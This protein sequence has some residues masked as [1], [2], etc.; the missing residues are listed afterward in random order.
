[1]M[2]IEYAMFYGLLGGIVRIAIGYTKK[3]P[4]DDDFRGKQA[5]RTI[6]VSLI[7]G[8]VAASL[9]ADDPRVAVIAGIGGSDFIDALWRGMTRNKTGVFPSATTKRKFSN[10]TARQQKGL[11][12]A[13]E[14][15]GITPEEYQLINSNIT[16]PTAIK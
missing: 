8:A 6:V 15:G 2:P 9:V 7:M 3:L 5:V 13:E 10:L 4:F 12:Y 11:D 1:M 14:H 16:R